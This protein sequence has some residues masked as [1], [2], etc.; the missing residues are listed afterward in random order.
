MPTIKLEG[1]SGAFPTAYDAWKNKH[2]E[3]AK[4][5]N[6]RKYGDERGREAPGFSETT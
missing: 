4:I 2:I 5:G 6:K 3:A 1:L